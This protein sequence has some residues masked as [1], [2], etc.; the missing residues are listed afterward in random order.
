MLILHPA[1]VLSSFIVWFSF[2]I[3]SLGAV[4]YS[5]I[6]SANRYSFASFPIFILLFAFSHLIPLA[7]T[8]S[9]IFNTRGDDIH[10]YLFPDFSV[11]APVPS[12]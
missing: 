7:F 8:S 6:F 1:A 9:K 4:T 5:V 11:N 2:S 3:D 10:P 12:R